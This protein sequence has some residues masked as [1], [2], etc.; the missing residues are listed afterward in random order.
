MKVDTENCKKMIT[1][2]RAEIA[3]LR[4]D[5]KKL[6]NLLRESDSNVAKLKKEIESVMNE[7]DI[8]GAQIVRRND[9]LSL[10]YQRIQTLSDTL[11]R[12]E[13]EYAQRLE[14]I[15]LLQLEVKKLCIDKAALTK[16]TANIGDLRGE[17]FHLERNL[18]KERLKVVALEEEVQNPLNIHRWRNLEV[19]FLHKYTLRKFI[20]KFYQNRSLWPILSFLA[21]SE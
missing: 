14:E 15:R 13:K 9:E 11:S 18:T 4:Q 16:N 19:M 12:G 5:E 8:I 7:R 21:E 17:V 1:D 6:R 20:A 10:Q 2:L 3:D